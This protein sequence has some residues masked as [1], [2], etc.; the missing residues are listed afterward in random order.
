MTKAKRS[1]SL[2]TK[3]GVAGLLTSLLAGY[4]SGEANANET[5]LHLGSSL[6]YGVLA[7]AA[8]TSATASGVTGT[9]GGNVGVGGA[10]A[11]SGPLNISGTQILGGA[12]LLALSDAASAMADN[13]GGIS[14]V[15]ELGAGRSII[16]GAYNGGALQI[17]GALTLNGQGDPNSVFIFRAA[18][19]LVTGA[20]S[21][22][23]LTNGAQSCNVYWQVG[24]SATLGSSSTIVGHVLAQASISTGVATEVNGQLIALTGAVTLGG[25]TLVNN[26]C[27]PPIV[28][29]PTPTP[30]VTQTASPTSTATPSLTQ[31]PAV[32]TLHIV[33]TVINRFGGTA[34]ASD[35]IIGV[36][37]GGRQMD[38]SPASAMDGGGRTYSLKPGT[39][40]LSEAVTDGYRGDWSGQI[41]LGGLVTLYPGDDITVTRTNYDLASHFVTET[42]PTVPAAEASQTPAE[43]ESTENG[44]LLP[45]TALP[46]GNIFLIG[47]A[48]LVGGI[49]GLAFRK[50]ERNI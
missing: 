49:I 22:V 6:S 4:F 34:K 42:S 8:I 33:K 50:W 43:S 37:Q 3:I 16:P 30:S 14:T 1:R 35:F 38:G 19:T 15:V 25:T 44:G 47:F 41:T 5:V 39:Y 48:L 12:S 24:S 32:A 13:R 11:P 46:W 23:L 45:N 2:L 20:S 18:S 7:S 31:S 27:L 26:N 28:A 36:T 9:A 21:T 40:I 10:T 29:T 17:N